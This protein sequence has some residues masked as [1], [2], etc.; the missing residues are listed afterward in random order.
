MNDFHVGAGRP[1]IETSEPGRGQRIRNFWEI[2]GA[3]AMQSET[4][5]LDARL[6]ER[7]ASDLPAIMQ[8]P[9]QHKGAIS[10]SQ[11]DRA[12]RLVSF[13]SGIE[14]YREKYRRA[15]I[16]PTRIDSWED[17]RKIPPI[18]KQELQAVYPDGCVHSSMQRDLC[19]QTRSSGSSGISLKIM[20]D[21]EAIATDTLHGIR[22]FSLQSGLRYEPSDSVANIY[23]VP[24]WTSAIDGYYINHFIS[25]L[26][27]ASA[28]ADILAELRPDIISLYPSNLEALM[29]H[30]QRWRHDDLD[31]IVTHS[32]QSTRAMRQTWQRMIGAPVLDEYSSEEGTRI[33]LECPCGHYH[34]CDD[35]VV[36]E[37][38]DPETML[39]QRPGKP[40]LVVVTNLLNHAMPFIRYV[41]G[42]L[43]T[44]G[45]PSNCPIQWGRVEN[46]Q[47]RV[48]DA[49]L[50]RSGN[51]VPAG[52]ILDAT[53]RMMFDN[54]INLRRFELVQTDYD[55]AR[56]TAPNDIDRKELEAARQRLA[57]LL[58]VAMEHPVKVEL[59]ISQS[60]SDDPGPKHRPIKRQ[61]DQPPG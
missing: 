49:F 33:A 10:D 44:L 25:S 18:T 41:Q 60:G 16:V 19:F 35:T 4:P 40:G 27:S 14:V 55:V 45:P 53:Y 31:L 34:S 24:W 13:A 46:I 11:L 51:L 12:A 2:S 7:L 43:A 30:R 61:F 54:N 3:P 52:T 59:V 48:N 1:F 6:R 28:T 38:L 9:F 39:P 37:I 17:F 15:G 42:D 8:A 57:E 23:T 36:L 5:L 26:I 50:T 20:V 47:G 32:E 21:L 58:A 29:H 22:Q 56:L